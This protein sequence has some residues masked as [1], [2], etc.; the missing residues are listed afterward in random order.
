MRKVGFTAEYVDQLNPAERGIYKSYYLRDLNA[1][2]LQKNKAAM[3]DV[4]LT[5]EDIM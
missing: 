3:A 5:P 2:L 1:K 4:G